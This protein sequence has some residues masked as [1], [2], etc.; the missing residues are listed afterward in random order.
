MRSLPSLPAQGSGRGLLS[1]S[2]LLAVLWAAPGCAGS[3]QVA[4]GVQWDN[5]ATVRTCVNPATVSGGA[6]LMELCTGYSRPEDAVDAVT[7]VHYVTVQIERI[8]FR[9]LPEWSYDSEVSIDVAIRGLL[10][11]GKEYREVLDIVHVKKEA[12]LQIQNVGVNFPIRFEN[13]VVSLEFS[14]RELDNGEEARRLFDRG[15]SMLRAVK[16]SPL[17][18]GFLGAV[19]V[20][21]IAE[22]VAT[23]ILDQFTK[24]D[25][26][27]SLKQVDFLPVTS[28]GTLQEQLLF[29]SG[30]YVA[31]AIPPADS[32]D[33]LRDAIGTYPERLDR[34]WLLDNTSYKGGMLM[35]KGGERD[36]M[37]SPYVA[38]NIVTLKRYADR[39]PVVAH[40]LAAERAI[41]RSKLDEARD[42]LALA[43]AN[44]AAD[45]GFSFRS[46]LGKRGVE[47]TGKGKRGFLEMDP[48]TIL[49]SIQPVIDDFKKKPLAALA[50]LLGLGGKKAEASDEPPKPKGLSVTGD[51]GGGIY[52]Q[53]E[54][55]LF[56][57]F[58]QAVGKHLELARISGEPTLGQLLEVMEAYL[59]VKQNRAAQATSGRDLPMS[60]AEC[61]VLLRGAGQVWRKAKARLG[62]SAHEA[63]EEGA[64]TCERVRE[65]AGAAEG[66][67]LCRTVIRMQKDLTWVTENCTAG[68][69][70]AY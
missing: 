61:E 38:F 23:V 33:P 30:R 58:L 29:T 55:S 43:D 54:Y 52:T 10:P 28:A 3:R 56:I 37:Y 69:S 51:A 5:H 34:Q 13:R 45:V 2:L 59:L 70:R 14:I 15:K 26:V 40:L 36:Y 66:A 12:F 63:I 4:G 27:F 25:H 49:Q 44:F 46:E 20:S 7:D 17:S 31:V 39:S 41:E 67:A 48:R 32:Y 65:V 19:L 53:L 11:G 22:D 24:P 50:G 6:Q 62:Y 42:H 16:S 21:E 9:D 1:C 68:K 8:F 60:N 35:L 18:G 57:D 47:L 64:R